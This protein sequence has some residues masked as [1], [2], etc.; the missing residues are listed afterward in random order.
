MIGIEENSSKNTFNES[1]SEAN[2]SN[3]SNRFSLSEIERSY[4][5][6]ID[7]LNHKINILEKEN[8]ELFLIKKENE[9]QI[10]H[11]VKR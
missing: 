10:E 5:I 3:F 1:V 2:V 8:D 11:L 9:G 6:K 4:Q 7:I